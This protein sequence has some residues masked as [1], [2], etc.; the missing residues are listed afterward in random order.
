M[1]KKNDAYQSVSG[2]GYSNHRDYF[3]PR[4]SRSFKPAS[5]VLTTRHPSSLSP[6]S[7]PITKKRWH[8][9]RHTKLKGLMKGS[10]SFFPGT[11]RAY[12]TLAHCYQSNLQFRPCPHF[13]VP[14]NTLLL[15]SSS[16]L[17]VQDTL[18]RLLFRRIL[19]RLIR[20][21]VQAARLNPEYLHRPPPRPPLW[22]ILSNSR[23]SLDLQIVPCLMVDQ[24]TSSTNKSK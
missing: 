24:P 22:P 3:N 16:L 9:F 15:S 5:S 8:P 12:P 18:H 21:S 2:R 14:L 10:G 20:A 7:S 19:L 1:E 13:T 17:A 11:M 23:S 6:L 4:R